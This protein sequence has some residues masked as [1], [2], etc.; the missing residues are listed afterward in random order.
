MFVQKVINEAV[1]EINRFQVFHPDDEAFLGLLVVIQNLFSMVTPKVYCGGTLFF[2]L[3]KCLK[4][5]FVIE[6]KVWGAKSK[7][8]E[9][10]F[11]LRFS[12]YPTDASLFQSTILYWSESTYYLFHC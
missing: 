10:V 9:L 7:M 12:F 2:Y 11:M 1:M 6:G 5:M 8:H 4:K 3:W